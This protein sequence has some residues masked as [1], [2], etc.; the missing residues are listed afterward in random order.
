MIKTK[1]VFV[2]YANVLAVDN[3]TFEFKEGKAPVLC[4]S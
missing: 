2:R 1:N 3:F 4:G